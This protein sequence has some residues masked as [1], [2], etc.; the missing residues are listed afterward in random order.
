MKECAFC[1]VHAINGSLNEFKVNLIQ[2]SNENYDVLFM[3]IKFL[4]IFR[5]EKS[6]MSHCL[7]SIKNF[8]LLDEHYDIFSD[9]NYRVRVCLIK[10]GLEDLLV[11]EMQYYAH[12][13]VQILTQ[14]IIR[15]LKDAEQNEMKY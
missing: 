3:L 1:I 5:S 2:N 14:E 4:I 12:E 8:L 6:L 10:Y 11:G 13:Q 7:L 15:M 9:G